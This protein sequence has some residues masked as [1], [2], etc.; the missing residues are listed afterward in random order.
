MACTTSDNSTCIDPFCF[1]TPVSDKINAA[2]FGCGNITRPLNKIYI[3]QEFYFKLL[4]N[5]IPFN[6]FPVIEYCSFYNNPN[7]FSFFNA[8]LNVLKEK[9]P[10][11]IKSCPYEGTDLQVKNLTLVTSDLALWIT[12]EYKLVYTFYDDQDPQIL[13]VS[14]KVA[15]CHFGYGLIT[16]IQCSTSEKNTCLEPFCNFTRDENNQSIVIAN[17]GCKELT[18]P[19]N[20]IMVHLKIYLK[21][22][23]QYYQIGFYPKFDYCEFITKFDKSSFLYVGVKMLKKKLPESVHECP[24]IDNQLQ[25]NNLTLTDNDFSFVPAG[26]YKIIV[27][28]SDD[29]DSRILKMTTHYKI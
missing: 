25:A 8:I 15:L 24:Y 27:T 7:V 3:K 13:Q 19:L 11:S 18:R 23:S 16:K 12:G 17:Y 1:V 4:Q 29:I 10:E 28:F 21:V 26:K 14:A 6:I 9:A 5:F 20:K 22:K 2:N